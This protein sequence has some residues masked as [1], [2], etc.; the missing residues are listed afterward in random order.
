MRR[1]GTEGSSHRS[2]EKGNYSEYRDVVH[3]LAL[4]EARKIALASGSDSPQ[5]PKTPI[6]ARISYEI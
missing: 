4:G 2:N 3:S 1:D 5:N 6:S